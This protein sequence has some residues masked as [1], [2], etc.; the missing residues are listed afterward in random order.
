MTSTQSVQSPNQQ[1]EQILKRWRMHRN[2]LLDLVS[3]IPES[4][5][6][7]RPWPTAWTTLDL[8]YHVAWTPDFFLSAAERRET[9]PVPIPTTINEARRLLREL[10]R[11]HEDAIKSYEDA[12]LERIVTI[13]MLFVTEPV[14][15]V[16]H[17]LVVHEAHHK[18]Q[19]WLYA[20]M[21]GIEPPF[22]ADL[23]V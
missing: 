7:W 18:G 10:T 5:A 3:K 19:L 4:S 15:E 11:E 23:S 8:L 9:N 2:A 1:V 21:M 14:V 17:R 13:P 22:Y 6:H 12:D 20:R 16:L